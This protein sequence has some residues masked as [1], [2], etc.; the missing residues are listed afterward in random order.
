MEQQGIIGI[1][2]LGSIILLLGG[3]VVYKVKPDFM[4]TK[5]DKFAETEYEKVKNTIRGDTIRG[6]KYRNKT[7]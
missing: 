5:L 7:T 1:S 2:V 4:K 3:I 6:G